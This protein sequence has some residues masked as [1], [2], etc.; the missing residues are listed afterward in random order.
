MNSQKCLETRDLFQRVGKSSSPGLHPGSK[1]G[2]VTMVYDCPS[3]RLQCIS[4]LL[5]LNCLQVSCDQPALLYSVNVGST[6]LKGVQ[7][8][9]L[10]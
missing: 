3:L 4:S 1:G 9:S 2:K 5:P 8:M 7:T 10:A 6:E